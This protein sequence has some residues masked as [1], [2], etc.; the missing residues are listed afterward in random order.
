MNVESYTNY[1]VGERFL[2]K[3]FSYNLYAGLA[4]FAF[5]CLAFHV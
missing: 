4:A 2:K 5:R 3:T 1:R